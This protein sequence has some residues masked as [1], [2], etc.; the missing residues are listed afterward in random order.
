MP[1]LTVNQA[2]RA[3]YAGRATIYRKIKT[4]ALPAELGD[5]G[6]AVIDTADLERVFG[7]PHPHRETSPESISNMLETAQLR[8]ENTLLRSENADLRLH[9]DRLMALLEQTALLT[10]TTGAG[11]SLRRLLGRRPGAQEPQ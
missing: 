6:Q 11:R 2:A 3:G 7:E 5:N 10:P 8:A 4:G 9:R 1:R